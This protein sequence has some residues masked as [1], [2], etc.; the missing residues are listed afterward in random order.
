MINKE[1]KDAT[2][3]ADGIDICGFNTSNVFSIYWFIH[4]YYKSSK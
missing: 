4:Y 3:F 2:E 1:I